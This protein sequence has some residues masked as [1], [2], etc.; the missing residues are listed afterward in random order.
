MW[1]SALLFTFFYHY[2]ALPIWNHQKLRYYPTASS[3]TLTFTCLFQSF[4]LFPIFNFWTRNENPFWI[5]LCTSVPS[6]SMYFT[7]FCIKS[8]CRQMFLGTPL[9]IIC[10]IHS[11]H[12]V[13]FLSG[14][15]SSYLFPPIHQH[16]KEWIKPSNKWIWFY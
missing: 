2:D 13:S 16:S 3:K 6:L 1:H 9:I 10:Q 14:V 12:L 15:L 11:L 5:I 4:F 8:L 7:F